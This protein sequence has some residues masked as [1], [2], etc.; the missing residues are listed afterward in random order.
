MGLGAA[1]T[2]RLIGFGEFSRF[3]G[4]W[5]YWTVRRPAGYGRLFLLLPQLFTI[6][7]RSIPVVMLVG[8]FVGAVI[9]IETY[10]QFQAIGQETRLGGVIALSVV[11][12]IGPVLAAVMIAGRVGG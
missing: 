1:L 6:G 12:Q 7:V 11:K 8:A 2:E 4:S 5:A 3:C 10:A 9:G